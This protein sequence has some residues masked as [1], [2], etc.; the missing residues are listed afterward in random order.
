MAIE[1]LLVAKGADSIG[2][3]IQRRLNRFELSPKQGGRFAP[4]SVAG[5]D[6]KTHD[7]CLA[8]FRIISVQKK[9]F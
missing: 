8:I 2:P 9:H 3:V 4:E 6:R 7:V 5:L 1:S